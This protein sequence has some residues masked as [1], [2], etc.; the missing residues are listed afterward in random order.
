MTI[1][2]N[3]SVKYLRGVGP[4]RAAALEERGISTVADLLGYLPFRYEDR[5]RFTPI[6]EIVPG[7]VHTILG[8]VASGGGSTVR[9]RRARGAVF[10]VMVRDNSGSMHARFFHG[11]YL[12]GRLK[13]GQRLVMHGKAD[14]DAYRPGRIEMVN[15]QIEIVNAS[16][17]GPGDSTEVGRIVPIY[18]AIGSISSRM[19]R[20]IIYGV[21]RDFDGDVPDVLPEEIRNRYRFPTR[22]EALL[23][24]HFPPKNENIELLN[25]FRSP[26]QTRLIF[27]EFFYYQLA[28]ALRRLREHRQQGIAMRVREEKVREALKRI[29][30]FKP[31]VAQK[32]VLVEIAGDLE[33]PYPM[34]RLLEGDVG[35]GKTI[36]ALEAA[37]IVI[38]NGYQV[39]LMAPTEILA[40]QHFL[41][42]RR[43][44]QAAGYGVDLIVSGRKRAEREAVLAR[45]QSG[46]TQLLVGTHA[47]IED[48]VKFS[49]LGLAIVDEQHRFGVLQ[50]KRLIDKGAAPHV[51]V[52]TAT[53]IPRT[54]ALTL[55][56][57][58]DLSVIDELPPG[59]TP[60]ET[61]WASEAQ[62]AGVWEF[63]R[64]EVASGRQGFVLYPVI[65]ES[66]QELKAATA[67]YERLAKS[68]FPKMRVGLLHGRLK[69]EEKDSVMD[70][71]RRAELDIL[72]ATTVIEVGV[73]VP[74]ATVMVIE[75]AERFGLAQLH[76]LR[77]RIG[78]GKERSHCIL[79]APKTI[80]GEARERIETMVATSNG[81]EIAERDLK[82]RG[83]GEFFGTRQ[84]GDAAFAFA[85]PLRDHELLEFARREAF[86]LAENPV[87]AEEL[88]ARLESVSPAWR[89]RYQL[90][91]VG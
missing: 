4:Q 26:A 47:L 13:E 16:D 81:F 44:F 70:R 45:V 24:T 75:H 12:E 36:V 82:L 8:E 87:R 79:I 19:L 17:E 55:Y 76:Q 80:T 15:P 14:V 33:R 68:V 66:K 42:A 35:S 63:L 32:R 72:V 90:A 10:H 7:Q 52:M 91:A 5:I 77:G 48:P 73:D 40:A 84:H 34:N 28:L 38:E 29:L 86:A 85:Q 51:L 54:L 20:R 67:E 60:I 78:R 62:L 74:N 64:R 3:N 41:S 61:R 11:A 21:L 59:R 53:P 57:D 6:A 9:F 46:E 37:T 58:L 1:A 25:T 18:E 23:Y 43:I 2:L 30:P 71:F 69:N 88:V 27:E 89:K 83:P 49:K 56:G 22:R 31:T 39:A 65:E 50:R